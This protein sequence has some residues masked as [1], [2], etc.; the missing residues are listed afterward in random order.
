M[1]MI[2]E[3]ANYGARAKLNELLTEV[4]ELKAFLKG[5]KHR[6]VKKYKR[7]MT[8]AKRRAMLRILK[9]ARAARWEKKNAR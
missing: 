4:K 8:P 2:K 1:L 3:L 6:L 5:R 7:R 9:K